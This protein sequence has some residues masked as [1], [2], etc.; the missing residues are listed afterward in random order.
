MKTI[1]NLEVARHALADIASELA[2]LDDTS[3]VVHES[4]EEEADCVQCGEKQIA[5]DLHDL[6]VAVTFTIV[7]LNAG[8]HAH[9]V[10]ALCPPRSPPSLRVDI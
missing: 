8:L 10:A 7:R 6:G 4:A 9:Q 3:T 1:E 5:Q 2:W